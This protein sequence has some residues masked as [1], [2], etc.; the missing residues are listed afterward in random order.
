M[1]VM[2]MIYKQAPKNGQNIPNFGEIKKL[3]LINDIDVESM[4]ETF[5]FDNNPGIFDLE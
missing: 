3:F 4:N 1:M 5:I 2:M